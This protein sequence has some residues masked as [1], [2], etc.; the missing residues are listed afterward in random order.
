ML[1]DGAVAEWLMAAVLKTAGA[2]ALVSSN[3]TRSASRSASHV[4]EG[5]PSVMS[6]DGRRRDPG[7]L[8]FATLPF[9]TLP[10]ALVAGSVAS[11][12]AG[13]IPAC[14]SVPAARCARVLF[15]G[16][17]CSL[18]MTPGAFARLAA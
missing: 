16:N 4:A 15:I 10:F 2:Q 12:L 8:A 3:L 7:A 11:A 14:A 1:R 9:A 6:P 17:S 18:S 5:R 13:R